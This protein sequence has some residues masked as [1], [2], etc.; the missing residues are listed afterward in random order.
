MEKAVPNVTSGWRQAGGGS[1]S[2]RSFG[3]IAGKRALIKRP[4]S[5]MYGTCGK[6]EQR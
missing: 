3:S 5:G 1:T 6:S 4:D 2:D